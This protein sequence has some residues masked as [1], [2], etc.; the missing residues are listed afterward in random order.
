MSKDT[1]TTAIPS[2]PQH[3]PTQHTLKQTPNLSKE[4]PTGKKKGHS[5]GNLLAI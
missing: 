2:T 4:T 3:N 1:L 5:K